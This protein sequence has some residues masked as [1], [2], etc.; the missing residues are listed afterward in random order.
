MI[1]GPTLVIIILCNLL[2][3]SLITSVAVNIN[4]TY[5]H[6]HK[7]YD[8]AVASSSLGFVSLGLLI[9]FLLFH[10]LYVNIKNVYLYSLAAMWI[11]LIILSAL[12]YLSYDKLVKS[13][14]YPPSSNNKLNKT[15]IN[16]AFAAFCLTIVGLSVGLTYVITT[17]IHE[18]YFDNMS[19]N[20]F[21]IK[22]FFEDLFG[23]SSE[24]S[25][26]SEETI[27]MDDLIS[28]LT[29]TRF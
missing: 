21:G 24:K 20:V 22:S 7:A 10:K 29:D 4:K 28:E 16:L 2:V 18:G 3:S 9:G 8:Y 23:E 27:E 26:V 13:K 25:K 15:E 19:G 6:D 11:V 17:G 12:T 1:I 14:N 5:H